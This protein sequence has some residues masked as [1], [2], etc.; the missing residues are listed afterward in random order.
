MVGLHWNV[1]YL[2]V[3][4]YRFGGLTHYVYLHYVVPLGYN[5]HDKWQNLE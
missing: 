2:Y 4:Q 1:L 5:F 3:V